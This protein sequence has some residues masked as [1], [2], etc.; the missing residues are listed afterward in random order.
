MD[1]QLYIQLDTSHQ[2]LK[3]LFILQ[4]SS[5]VAFS[6]LKI[7]SR[8][9]LIQLKSVENDMKV[10]YDCIQGGPNTFGPRVPQF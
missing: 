5:F 9:G 8:I 4:P 6:Q 1:C 3:H 10:S 7:E 2:A